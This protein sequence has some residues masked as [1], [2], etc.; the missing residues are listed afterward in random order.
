MQSSLQP[1]TILRSQN[2]EYRIEKM[3]G[4]GG[5][6]ITYLAIGKFKHGN[7]TVESNFAIKEHFMET[8][9][10]DGD[11]VTVRCTPTSQISVEQSRKDFLN[12]AKKLQKI[13][14]L[15]EH[16]VNVN[17][18]FEA[19]GTAYYVMEYLDGGS[20]GKMDEKDAVNLILQVA[21]A[22]KTLHD[23]KL[24]HLDIKPDN[25]LVKNDGNG[26]ITPVLIDFGLAKHFDK[27]G[28]PTSTPNAKGLTQGFAPVEQG[29]IIS[30]FAPTLDVYAL[31]ATLLYLLTGKNPP[32]STELV[33]ANQ[34]KLKTLIPANVSDSTRNAILHAMTPNKD[35]RTPNVSSFINELTNGAAEIKTPSTVSN[36]GNQ[37]VTINQRK[38]KPPIDPKKKKY[39]LWGL[40]VVVV[41]AISLFIIFATKDS[42]AYNNSVKDI[43][44][45]NK[46]VDELN[47]AFAKEDYSNAI[48]LANQIPDNSRAQFIL[49]CLYQNGEG[50]QQD[51]HKA[52]EWYTKSADNNNPEAMSNIGYMYKMGQGT[53][54]DYD[55]AKKWYEKAADLG[56][57]LAMWNMGFFYESGLGVKQ[58]YNEAK[59]GI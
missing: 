48:Q 7:V 36:S 21:E 37:T 34:T 8:C 40:G 10:R 4:S 6:G 30:E 46:I 14:Q 29:G 28:N 11:G 54:I 58:D 42:V 38:P 57:E 35:L 51:Y 18:T 13:C 27:K 53:S 26:N 59:N 19:N 47:D 2:T 23:N 12:E 56:D 52:L 41:V 5:F 32:S 3:L 24:L 45:E 17:E 43:E 9:Y 55:E 44:A 20:P 50:V 31:G 22:V 15:S 25:I 33:D 49:G 39:I 16:I 1:G